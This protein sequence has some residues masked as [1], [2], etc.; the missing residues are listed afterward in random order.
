MIASSHTR[1]L[2]EAERVPLGVK[3]VGASSRLTKLQV[4]DKKFA[5]INR[6]SHCSCTDWRCKYDHTDAS[7]T[8]SIGFASYAEESRRS[9]ASTMEI[10]L[11]LKKLPEPIR[12]GVGNSLTVINAFGNPMTF[13]LELCFSPDVCPLYFTL[14]SVLMGKAEAPRFADDLF[15]GEIRGRPRQ[16]PQIH[17]FNKGWKVNSSG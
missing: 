16:G 8:T 1:R 14:S 13:P 7:F 5:I 15:Q 10:L 4:S 2:W 11:A 6:I 12:Y 3:S 17:H 9:I